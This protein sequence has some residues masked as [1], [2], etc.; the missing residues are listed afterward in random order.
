MDTQHLGNPDRFPII[1]KELI[2]KLNAMFPEASAH[3]K[4]SVNELYFKGGQRDVIR[5]L[6]YYYEKQT[7]QQLN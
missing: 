6:N 7:G 1:S 5:K 2:E 4:D 3:M